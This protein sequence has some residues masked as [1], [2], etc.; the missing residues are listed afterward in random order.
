MIELYPYQQ[1]AV[2]YAKRTR[3]PAFLMEMRLG[4]TPCGIK[5]GTDLYDVRTALV[6]APLTT[7]KGWK[8]F[9]WAEGEPWVD[10]DQVKPKEREEAIVTWFENPHRSWML[11]NYEKLRI[12]PELAE[13]P[14]DYVLMDESRKIAN[15]ASQ[16]S[17]L[18]TKGFRTARHRAIL[19]G[20]PAPESEIEVFQQFKFL[21][22]GF[23]GCTSYWQ[24]RARYYQPDEYGWSPKKGTRKLIKE[25][26]H[27]RA[28]VLTRKDAGIGSKKMVTRRT[29]QMS[30]EQLKIYRDVQK[31]YAW[32]PEDDRWEET[33]WAMTAAQWLQRLCGGF[34]PD[35]LR[36]V[37]D[38]KVR[39]ML[40]LFSGDLK[41]ERAVVWFKFRAE[42][43]YV[44]GELERQGYRCVTVDGSVSPADRELAISR[45]QRGDAQFFLATEKTAKM[46]VDCSVADVA[47]YYSN[48]WSVEDRLQSEDRI[49]NPGKTDPLLIVDLVYEGTIDE[50]VAD[51]VRTRGF[52]A[53]TLMMKHLWKVN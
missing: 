34:T 22:G 1:R 19:C 17:K 38:A 16:I 41:G 23:M 3:S 36:V 24:F 50:D 45:F 43:V 12:Y 51:K 20:L 9:L 7:F 52:E 30:P 39:E 10:L 47:I 2:A 15:P 25:A 13:M 6:V 46:G 27:E 35:G 18:V 8:D 31:D 21:D 40:Y 44:R 42:L 49:V 48:E 28:F 14:I 53:K 5:C 29:V 33:Q 32:K 4:K 37:S 11:C 26:M